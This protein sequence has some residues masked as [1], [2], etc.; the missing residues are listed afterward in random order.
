[1][2]FRVRVCRLGKIPGLGCT[3]FRPPEIS[4]LSFKAWGWGLAM[5]YTGW[6]PKPRSPKH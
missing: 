4:G 1:M 2:G 6:N 3:V 5:D